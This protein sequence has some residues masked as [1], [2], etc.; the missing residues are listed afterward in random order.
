VSRKKRYFTA[1]TG[2]LMAFCMVSIM[3]QNTFAQTENDGEN[4]TPEPV[5]FLRDDDS[6]SMILLQEP[7][8]ETQGAN[9]SQTIVLEIDD[10]R[11]QESPAHYFSLALIILL[12][13]VF[14]LL[15]IHILM[16]H[17][18]EDGEPA[19]TPAPSLLGED[20]NPIEDRQ[21]RK[22]KCEEEPFPMPLALSVLEACVQDYGPGPS[23][24]APSMGYPIGY[25]DL[26]S[27]EENAVE[28]DNF[29][30]V[31]V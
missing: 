11:A 23:T 24:R 6:S 21:P 1:I 2:L 27:W 25:A 17:I 10:A 8:S 4:N 14:S 9:T 12:L 15:L 26:A 22:E 18:S 28:E 3:A 19:T 13:L 30:G 20:P 29:E 31:I 7:S 16:H 5:I